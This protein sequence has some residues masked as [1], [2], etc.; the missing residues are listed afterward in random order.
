MNEQLPLKRIFSVLSAGVMAAV[1]MSAPGMTVNTA[2]D[3][4]DSKTASEL[5]ITEG[6][7][8]AK[9]D[10]SV[11]AL[12]HE[13]DIKKGT[14]TLEKYEVPVWKK[15]G[16]SDYREPLE[17][18]ELVP[19]AV[20]DSMQETEQT[21]EQQGDGSYVV[22]ADAPSAY[23][24]P[25]AQAPA[26]EQYEPDRFYIRSY[27][28]GHGVGMAQIGANYYAKNLG[29]NYA[30]ILGHYYPGT[31]IEHRAGDG[32]ETISVR[33]VSGS[34]VDILSRVCEAE[35]GASFSDEA[36]KAQA[37]AAYSY[38]KYYGGSTSGMAIAGYTPSERIVNLVREV[39]GEAVYYNGSYAL[40]MFYAQSG[41]CTASNKDI[42]Y[43]D[44]PYLRS[45]P[46]DVDAVYDTRYYGCFSSISVSDMYNRLVNTYHVS[47]SYDNRDSWIQLVPGD[48]GYISNVI[49][50]GQKTVKGYDFAR[51]VLGIGTPK[52]TIEH[53]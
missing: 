29:W 12:N 5:Q 41:G 3:D 39:A 6:T 1:V 43:E 44:I 53:T 8:E 35:V 40:A 28:K 26:P 17:L 34:V 32:S 45:V 11:K 7:D 47:L 25:P 48:G 24:L 52:Y 14:T 42:N 23:S 20:P 37:V 27:G 21:A 33:G 2:A 4:L 18:D 30:Q 38:I 50:G 15:A 46:C 13:E 19:T 22:N 51:N 31:T 36:I 9:A 49:I 16:L 10:A